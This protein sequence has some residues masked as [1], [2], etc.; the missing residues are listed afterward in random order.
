MSWK[1]RWF[2]HQW[3]HIIGSVRAHATVPDTLLWSRRC[4][5]CGLVQKVCR[6]LGWDFLEHEYID[7]EPKP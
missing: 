7:E 5:R 2:G 1:C 3:R 4:F 6:Q